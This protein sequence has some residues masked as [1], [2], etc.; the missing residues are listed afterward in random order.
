MSSGG[1]PDRGIYLN[2]NCELRFLPSSKTA[3]ALIRPK[4]PRLS[5]ECMADLQGA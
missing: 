1:I 4:K 5:L 3:T 2:H